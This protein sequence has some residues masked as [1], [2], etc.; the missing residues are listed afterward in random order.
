MKKYPDFSNKMLLTQYYSKYTQTH[1]WCTFNLNILYYYNI[2]TYYKILNCYTQNRTAVSRVFDFDFNN[3]RLKTYI[4]GL[5]P[6]PLV[7]L[8]LLYIFHS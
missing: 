5:S 8:K 6:P 4:G 1:T 7:T 3:K 2:S